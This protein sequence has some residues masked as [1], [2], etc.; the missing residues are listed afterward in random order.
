L[1]RRKKKKETLNLS[2]LQAATPSVE[3]TR[4]H[5]SGGSEDFPAVFSDL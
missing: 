4:R 3:K 5:Y 1:E 2:L